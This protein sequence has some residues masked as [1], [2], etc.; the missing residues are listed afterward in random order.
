MEIITSLK[1]EKYALKDAHSAQIQMFIDK[2]K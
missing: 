1:E 2:I